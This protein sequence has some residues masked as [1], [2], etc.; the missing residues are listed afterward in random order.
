[1]LALMEEILKL[2]YTLLHTKTEFYMNLFQILYAQEQISFNR[3]T[4]IHTTYFFI[5][6]RGTTN[7]FLP[8]ACALNAKKI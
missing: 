1:M 6:P 3:T 5:C 4:K 8:F 7:T 2:C